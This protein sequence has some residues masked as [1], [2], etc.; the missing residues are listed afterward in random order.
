M[1]WKKHHSTLP[2][3][4]A[5]M[6][7]YQTSIR[8]VLLSRWEQPLAL[9]YVSTFIFWQQCVLFS[10]CSIYDEFVKKAVKRAQQKKVGDPF[11]SN[12]EQGPQ[13]CRPLFFYSFGTYWP[14]CASSHFSPIVHKCLWPELLRNVSEKILFGVKYPEA[15]RPKSSKIATLKFKLKLHPF[16]IRSKLYLLSKYVFTVTI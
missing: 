10:C 1:P 2:A 12:T 11:D 9:Q 14:S 6:R 15:C 3:M 7:C 4:N 5:W 8:H 16:M 13:V